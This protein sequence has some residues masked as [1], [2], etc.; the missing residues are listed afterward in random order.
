MGSDIIQFLK[1]KAYRKIRDLGHGATGQTVLLHDDSIDEDFV[2]KK[3]VPYYDYYKE[4]CYKRFVDEIKILYK[5]NHPRIVRVFNYYLYPD[6]WTGYILMEYINGSD[7][8]QY[9]SSSPHSFDD[10]FKQAIDGFAYLESQNIL[11]RDIRTTNI[12]VT[13]Q[14][15]VKIIDFGFSKM[16]NEHE[17]IKSITLNWIAT[18][19]NEMTGARPVYNR[20]TEVYFVGCLF[21]NLLSAI[22]ISSQYEYI[23][24][25][26]CKYNPDDRFNDFRNVIDAMY[27]GY[28]REVSE[29]EKKKYQ[30]FADTL[31]SV[32]ASIEKSCVYNQNVDGI[33]KGMAGLLTYGVL[34][35]E[36]QNPTRFCGLFLIG[37]YKYKNNLPVSISVIKDFYE[38]W[39][40][41]SLEMKKIT[42]R[43]LWERL[44]NIPRYDE[45]DLPF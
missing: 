13:N 24:D 22:G 33:E 42:I 15:E 17:D 26:M 43:I 40:A 16:H 29:R 44:D 41:E 19:P 12:L 3:Y 35:D 9:L 14:G 34:E 4:E 11:H 37:A 25:K 6:Q 21:R 2:C 7:I 39:I 45:P 31:C 1:A 27:K 20:S 30:S 28:I 38:W 10:L 5:M 18:K 36:L 32:I 23:I 8:E